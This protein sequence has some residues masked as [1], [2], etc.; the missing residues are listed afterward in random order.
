[1]VSFCTALS[2]RKGGTNPFQKFHVLSTEARLAKLEKLMG[3]SGIV[4][5][6][7]KDLWTEEVCYASRHHAIEGSVPLRR[8]HRG[9]IIPTARD[10][11]FLVVVCHCLLPILQIEIRLSHCGW[12]E[13]WSSIVLRD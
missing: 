12:V 10:S 2:V 9:G 3:C 7:L 4:Q 6:N 5:D 11:S 8:R 1:M 13:T